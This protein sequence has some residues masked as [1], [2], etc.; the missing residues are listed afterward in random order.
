MSRSY[1]KTPVCQDGYGTKT[2]QWYKRQSNKKVRRIA[3]IASGKAYRKVYETWIF[4]D[5]V[6]RKTFSQYKSERKSNLKYCLNVY[7]SIDNSP[8][9]LKREYTDKNYKWLKKIYYWK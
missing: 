4:R 9:W 2:L 7:G 1:R 6:F 3:E 5:Y 8:R